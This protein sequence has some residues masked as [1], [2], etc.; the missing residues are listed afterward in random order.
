M[1]NEVTRSPKP[2]DRQTPRSIRP[3]LIDDV[4]LNSEESFP[5]SDPPSWTPVARVGRPRP[6]EGTDTPALRR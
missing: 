2:A 4:E 3:R 1:T 5:A 6:L